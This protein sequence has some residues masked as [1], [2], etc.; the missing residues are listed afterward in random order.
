[1]SKNTDGDGGRTLWHGRFAGGPADAL[2]A[3]TVSLPFDR[4]LWRQDIAGSR[5]HVRGLGRAGLFSDGDVT[6]VLAAL[7]I[8]ES[9]FADGTFVVVAGDEDIHTAV[10]RRV[11]EIAGDAGA[12]IHTARSRNDQVATDL[13]LWTKEALRDV[14]GA[15]IAL[16]EVLVRRADEHAD[17][18]LPGYTHLQRAQPVLLSHHLLAHV[19][20]FGRDVDRLLDCVDRLDVSPLGAGA[21]AGT[22][23]PI[24]PVGTASDLGFAAVFDNSLD[25]VS[26]R[27]FVAEAL[28]CLSMI[29]LHLARIGEE[30]VLWT[31]E[32]FG[33]VLLDDAYATGSSML[34]QKKNADIAELAR[35]K[36]GRLIGNLTGLLATLKGLPLAYNRDLQE[37]KEPLF[38]S[39]RQVVLALAAVSGMIDTARFNT[40]A[41]A[42]AADADVTAATDLA[43]FLVRRGVPFRTAHATVGEL[44]RR[45]LAGEG[46]LADLARSELGDEVADLFAP[47]AQV[48]NRTS[49][50]VAGPQ[51][52]PVQR[53]A[54]DELLAGQR[55]R[56]SAR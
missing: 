15:V 4:E 6:A 55:Q 8:V 38:D 45:H 13:R 28:F 36:S 2:M 42:A 47:G 10:E 50:G 39:V 43:E 40:D 7:D 3:Y 30:W 48:R 44:V 19:W 31:S 29:G 17:A 53:A 5:A 18:R 20:A 37:D 54:I 26:D 16:Q 56:V 22:S 41:M 21:L 24:D 1:M 23:L 11:T 14:V 27:D 33:F 46:D 9:E 32:E 52:A 35:G 49:R 51:A 12:R 25:A 34:P